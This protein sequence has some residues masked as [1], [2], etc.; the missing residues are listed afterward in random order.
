MYTVK[1][2]YTYAI[3]LASSAAILTADQS[4][5][6]ADSADPNLR[7]A[8]ILMHEAKKEGDAGHHDAARQLLLKACSIAPTP[9][10]FRSLAHSELRSGH[11]V[12]SLHH[13]RQELAHPSVSTEVPADALELDRS[14]MKIAYAQAGHVEIH[15]PEGA[16]I[17]VDGVQLAEPLPPDRILD[18][19]PGAHRLEA[20]QGDILAR[21]ETTLPAGTVVHVELVP[22][23][24]PPVAV[25]PAPPVP[26]VAPSA[27]PSLPPTPPSQPPPAS[28]WWTGMHAAGVVIA[29][30]G[31]V[32]MVVSGVFA[33]QSQS[34]GDS[35]TKQQP[36]V[37]DCSGLEASASTEHSA[38]VASWAFFGVGAAALAAGAVLVFLP[39]HRSIMPVASSNTVGLQLLGDF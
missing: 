22:Q 13:F 25:A 30:A 33:A 37:G 18:L 14:T 20:R 8:A 2:V 35:V 11:P 21:S 28:T 38:S 39:S 27:V 32:S 15:A 10:C 1:R 3:L 23:P 24:P 16:A 12:D 31:V 29:G 9:R 26:P 6:G 4:A 7:A 17:I 34:A 36:C 19:P 5:Y